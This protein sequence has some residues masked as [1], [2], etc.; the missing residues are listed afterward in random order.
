MHIKECGGTKMRISDSV[1]G[2][3]S[4]GPKGSEGRCGTW[5]RGQQAQRP[6]GT[7]LFVHRVATQ[8]SI[9]DKGKHRVARPEVGAGLS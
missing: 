2:K 5:Q 8:A 3:D 9:W 4:Q 1:A 7:D 6:W